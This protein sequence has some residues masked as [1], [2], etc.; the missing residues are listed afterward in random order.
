MNETN[1]IDKLFL[2]LSQF[3][4]AMTKRELALRKE[5]ALWVQLAKYQREWFKLN[6]P[7][8]TSA[9]LCPTDAAIAQ[10]EKLL[11]REVGSPPASKEQSW[12]SLHSPIP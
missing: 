4:S 7:A 3:T 2:E 10:S 1:I 11:G 6:H 5:V 8:G 9:G 12:T